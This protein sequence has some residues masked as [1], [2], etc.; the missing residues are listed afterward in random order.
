MENNS[1]PVHQL[2]NRDAGLEEEIIVLD[3]ESDTSD[4]ES[5]NGKASHDLEFRAFTKENNGGKRY[6]QFTQGH[7]L[8]RRR[9]IKENGLAYFGCNSRKC[10]VTFTAKYRDKAMIYG[11]E[12]PTIISPPRSVHIC[13]P[14]P[15]SGFI[16]QAKAW[17]K[18][19]SNEGGSFRVIISE[20]MKHYESLLSP[21]MFRFF[22]RDMPCVD[23]MVV[24]MHRWKKQSSASTSSEPPPT[25]N[26]PDGAAAEL[27]LP[28]DKP[29][30]VG[31]FLHTTCSRARLHSLRGNTPYHTSP[32]MPAEGRFKVCPSC[33]KKYSMYLF[34]HIC[35][36]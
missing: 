7:Y 33:G 24:N 8:F 4:S 14:S 28:K 5:N 1:S 19:R 6:H 20:V 35:K 15:A 21:A 31:G 12:P 10:K 11:T 23:S 9:V 16:R 29:Y 25:E 34:R 3:S 17:L 13:D 22:K 2:P 30:P 32:R 36:Q 26:I 27:A 18:V